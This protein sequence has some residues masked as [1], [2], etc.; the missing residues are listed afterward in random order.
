[1]VHSLFIA[2]CKNQIPHTWLLNPLSGSSN[3]QGAQLGDLLAELLD[4]HATWSKNHSL[5]KIDRAKTCWKED[6]RDL[7]LGLSLK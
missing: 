4:T 5:S 3:V 2:P 7:L 6:S 1:M